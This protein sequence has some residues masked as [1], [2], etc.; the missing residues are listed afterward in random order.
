MAQEWLWHGWGECPRQ[1]AAARAGRAAADAMAAA[2]AAVAAAAAAAGLL[3]LGGG[4]N[5]AELVVQAADEGGLQ[6]LVK[7]EAAEG[8]GAAGAVGDDFV[9]EGGGEDGVEVFEG[10]GGADAEEGGED[11][12]EEGAAELGATGEVLP[13][14]LGRKIYDNET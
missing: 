1:V 12:G 10:G 3:L 6:G 8:D 14:L 2:A 9:G 7:D 11:D 13:K 5:E 4:E